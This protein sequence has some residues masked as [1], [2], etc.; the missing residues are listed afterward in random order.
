VGQL[1]QRHGVL[2]S[3]LPAIQHLLGRA[4]AEHLEAKDP[5]HIRAERT[6]DCIHVAGQ[7]IN[8]G[9]DQDERS[10]ADHDAE[11]GEAGAQLVF[12]ECV[13]GE[14]HRLFCIMYTHD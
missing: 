14:V 12:A 1:A 7:P 2:V 13:E 4:V 5:V 11:D 8:D 6:H 10:D 9:R 3:E